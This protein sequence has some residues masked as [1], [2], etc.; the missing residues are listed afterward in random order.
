MQTLQCKQYSAKKCTEVHWNSCAFSSTENY[1]TVQYSTL[2]CDFSSSDLRPP[3]RDKLLAGHVEQL[4]H[5][6]VQHGAPHRSQELRIIKGR[7][8]LFSP[9]ISFE[10]AAPGRRCSLST[11]GSCD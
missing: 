9:S 7:L 5:V 3:D 2:R 4:H 8:R 1:S 11:L 6:P 10:A